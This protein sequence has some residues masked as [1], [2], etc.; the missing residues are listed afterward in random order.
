MRTSG[1]PALSEDVT[2][3][4]TFTVDFVC[5]AASVTAT[6]YLQRVANA[7][8]V[9]INNNNIVINVDQGLKKNNKNNDND[10]NNRHPVPRASSMSIR[11]VSQLFDFGFPP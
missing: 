1:T 4:Q 2:R 9:V 3:W 10:N 5:Y 6:F 11:Y 7:Y 8:Q